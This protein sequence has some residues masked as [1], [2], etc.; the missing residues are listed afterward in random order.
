MVM[1]G[2]GGTITGGAARMPLNRITPVIATP[3]TSTIT[4]RMRI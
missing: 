3:R 2:R 4:S 1:V